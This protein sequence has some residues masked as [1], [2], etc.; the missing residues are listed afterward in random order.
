M[1][2]HNRWTAALHG[3]LWR[4][5]P[6]W[7]VSEWERALEDYHAGIVEPALG[8]IEILRPPERWYTL[9]LR[10]TARNV[11]DVRPLPRADIE[12]LVQ[13]YGQ[14]IQQL[15]RV[16]SEA[17]LRGLEALDYAKRVLHDEGALAL[18][19]GLG[20]WVHWEVSQ[21]RRFFT[22]FFLVASELPEAWVR[23]H[24]HHGRHPSS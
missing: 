15:V 9:R 2:G 24:R 8:E 5:S 11:L 13:E 1:D 16:S 21:A 22:L 18:R 4:E 17:P 19:E 6:A 23:F 10:D 12:P 20:G 3:A 7:R 14:T